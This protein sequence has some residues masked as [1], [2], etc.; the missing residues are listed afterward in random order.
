VTRGYCLDLDCGDGRLSYELAKQTDLNIYA[1]ASNRQDLIRA[2]RLLDDAG[3]YGTR[4]T[5]LQRDLNDTGLPNYFANLIVSGNSVRKGAAGVPLDEMHRML[6]PYGGVACL[7]AQGKMRLTKRGSLEDAGSWTHQY[8][9]PANTGCSTDGLVRAPLG[10]LWFTDNDFEMP[11]RHGRA[12]A[13]LCL[14]GRLFVEGLHGLRALDAYNGHVLWEYPLKDIL[15]AYDQEHLMGVAGTGSN[16]CVAGEGLYICADDKCLRIDSATGKLRAQFNA[17]AHPEGEKRVW[18]YLACTNGIVF[19]S[20]ADTGHIV[21]YRYGRSDMQTQFTESGLLFAMDA[22]TGKPKWTYKP[23]H[24]IRNNSIAIGN[25]KMYF[26]DGP[27]VSGDRTRSAKAETSPEA[28]TKAAPLLIALDINDGEIAW[29]SSDNIYGTMLAMSEEHDMLLM[30]YQ[31]TRF[32]L[33]SEIGGRMA[34]LRA[35]DGKQLWDVKVKYASRPIVNGSTIYAQPGAWDLLTGEKKD[36]QLDRS[37]GCGILAG[38]TNLLAFR[39]ATLGYR[40]LLSEKPT[41][42]YGGIRPGCWINTIPAGGLLLMP[43]A[44][45]RCVCSYLIK[46][47][48]ALQPMHRNTE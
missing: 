45:N 21:T 36:F 10:V 42:N 39:S 16:F 44:S 43:E 6:R 5:V 13:P 3:L 19:G 35:S 41:D 38:S 14:D 25:G 26:I 47:T 37:Y 17:P 30:S 27:Q 28:A 46:A 31:D 1:V 4:V 23:K 20:L 12:P 2:R 32:K 8:C 40:D 9:D 33:A 29:E 15:K 11:S 48:I 24:S 18:S 22:K 34:G 7:A